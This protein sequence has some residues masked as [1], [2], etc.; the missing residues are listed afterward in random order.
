MKNIIYIKYYNKNISNRLI[1]I[2]LF[3]GIFKFRYFYYINLNSL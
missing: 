1:V 2:G 3:R